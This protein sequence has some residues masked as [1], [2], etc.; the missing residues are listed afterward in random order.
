[1]AV[2]AAASQPA[3]SSFLTFSFT[4][5][6]RACGP[7]ELPMSTAPPQKFDITPMLR[8]AENEGYMKKRGCLDAIGSWSHVLECVG[9]VCMYVCGY[10]CG[11]EFPVTATGGDPS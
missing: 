1:M 2:L 5:S 8:P 4:A 10:G 3:I 9:R 11:I 7:S 6:Q